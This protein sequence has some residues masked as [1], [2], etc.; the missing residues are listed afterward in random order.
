LKAADQMG[1]VLGET[2]TRAKLRVAK[3]LERTCT[4]RGR[5]NYKIEVNLSQ[6]GCGE[7]EGLMFFGKGDSKRKL[8]TR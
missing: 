5:S 7:I 2:A 4:Q 1:R 6:W 8:A 3:V